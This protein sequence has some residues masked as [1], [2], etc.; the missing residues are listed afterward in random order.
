MCYPETVGPL[1]KSSETPPRPQLQRVRNP[2]HSGSLPPPAEAGLKQ[3]QQQEFLFSSPLQ[4]LQLP[5]SLLPSTQR[6]SGLLLA[7]A[8]HFK[9]MRIILGL[10]KSE[11]I[12]T[13]DIFIRTVFTRHVNI[14][15]ITALGKGE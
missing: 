14:I 3:Q 8:R 6:H 4:N 7:S 11:R 2:R 12:K 5:K 13:W 9:A 10:D 1:H 15:L